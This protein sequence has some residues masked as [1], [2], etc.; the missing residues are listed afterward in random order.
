MR[1]AVVDGRRSYLCIISFAC[2]EQSFQR[3]VS[4]NDKTCDIDKEFSCNVEE[5]E[6]EV[7]C[8]E[9]EESVDFG[10]RGLLLEVVEHRIL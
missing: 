7:N 6:E 3:I 4:W 1:K 8:D 10:Y 5:D 9:A 2:A